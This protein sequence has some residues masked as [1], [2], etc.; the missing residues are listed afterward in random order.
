M[1]TPPTVSVIIPAH[2]AART[3]PRC[4]AAIHASRI[5]PKEI[6]VV[7]DHSDDDSAAIARNAGAT[8]VRS[9]TRAGPAS[10]RNLGAA[11]AS[12]DL[13]FFVD[14][15][16]A[17][18]ADALSQ[19]LAT[20][21]DDPALAACFGSYDD[22]PAEANFLSQYKNLLHHYVHQTAEEE[23]FTFWAG[24][25][26]IRRAI[27]AEVGGFDEKR[28][29]HPAIEDIELGY[30]LRRRGYA[31]RL[32]K[33]MQATHLKRWSA[34]SLLRADIFG[35]AI[36][37]SHLLL[38]AGQIPDDLN[39]R[40]QDRLSTLATGTLLLGAIATLRNRRAWPVACLSA[41]SLLALNLPLYRFFCRQR[42]VRF[43]L[44]AIPWHW[45]YFLYSGL[46]FGLVVLAHRFGDGA[47][48]T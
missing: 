34:G 22:R 17:I 2:N 10:A 1:H 20:L 15:D 7:D 16:V 38:D 6:I 31:I 26:M 43:T 23:A 30:R 32:C 24:C 25:G 46:S 9:R 40:A 21:E 41:L 37:W 28:Y 13:V 36:P 35:R 5:P 14:A 39:L 3:L 11:H 8:V 44:Q 18:H 33:A 29:P 45:L 48:Q 42:G 47:R 12:G 19:A 4:L 27:F